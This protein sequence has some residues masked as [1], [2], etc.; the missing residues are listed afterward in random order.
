MALTVLSSTKAMTSK[1]ITI[2]AYLMKT[3]A[4]KAPSL[5]RRET[6]SRV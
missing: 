1:T 2:A 4:V 3:A 5:F 6:D